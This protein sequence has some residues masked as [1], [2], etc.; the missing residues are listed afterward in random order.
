M[1]LPLIAANGTL[2][3]VSSLLQGTRRAEREQWLALMALRVGAG[4]EVVTSTYS[5][6]ATAGSIP[7][8]SPSTSS[9]GSRWWTAA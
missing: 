1:A 2:A 5:F 9:P 7:R 3:T 4:D 8:P 6:F